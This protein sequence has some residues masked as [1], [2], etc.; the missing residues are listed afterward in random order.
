MKQN[1]GRNCVNEEQKKKEINNG[2]E[3]KATGSK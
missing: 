2:L 1:K 3:D